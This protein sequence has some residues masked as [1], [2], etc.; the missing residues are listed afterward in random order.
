MFYLLKEKRFAPF[1]WTQFLGAF[2]DNVFKNAL[3]ILITYQISKESESGT[4]VSMAGGLF[5]L[6][7]IIFSAIAGQ[8]SDKFEKSS[9]IVFT[10]KLETIIMLIAALGFWLNNIYFLLFVLF[11]M[12]TQSAIFGPVKYS[13]IPQVLKTEAELVAGT[14]LVEMGTFLAIVLGTILGGVLI[15][16]SLISVS[17]A[18]I[19]F[20]LLGWLSACFIPKLN[21][22]N[23]NLKIKYQPIAQY[24][25][26]LKVSYKNPTVFYSIL[27]ISWFWFFGACYLTQI[28]VY[29]KFIL[30]ANKEVVTAILSTF[31]FS[32]A[33]GS[34]I[35]NLLSE[36]NR[37]RPSFHWCNWT[38]LIFLG[39]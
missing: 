18:V 28:P 14:S 5:I 4:L 29:S 11:A 26:M 36:T 7:F 37:V 33:V 22:Q 31:V 39:S 8:I 2:N 20:S 24:K 21:A 34:I 25:S 13:L 3:I 16:F 12:G 10:K 32:M 35:C 38:Q 6:P 23:P 19:I 15:N 30:N 1:F 27:A 9:F 17:I